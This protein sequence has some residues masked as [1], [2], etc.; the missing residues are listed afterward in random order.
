M[1]NL[2]TYYNQGDFTDNEYHGTGT[3]TWAD[4]S[5]YTGDFVHGRYKRHR[6]VSQC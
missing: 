6:Y 3:Y 1:T 5:C 2:C 4:G